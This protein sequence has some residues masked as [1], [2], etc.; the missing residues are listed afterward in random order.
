MMQK[1]IKLISLVMASVMVVIL[2]S[3]APCTA[4]SKK[5]L[6]KSVEVQKY[7]K[8]TKQWESFKLL[9]YAY[10]KKGD[11]VKYEWT[12]GTGYGYFTRTTEYTYR[13]NGKRKYAKYTQT[14]RE[15]D[16]MGNSYSTYTRTGKISY[17][18]NGTRYKEKYKHNYK[19]EGSSTTGSWSNTDRKKKKKY[20]FFMD[21]SDLT[22]KQKYKI[23]IRK[24]GILKKILQ[25]DSIDYKWRTRLRFNKEGLIKGGYK[26]THYKKNGL[27][28][29]VT[30][31]GYNG[32]YR[33]I[34][35]Y[36]KKSTSKIRYNS[37]INS[38]IDDEH[39]FWY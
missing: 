14:G 35:K 25:R 15:W 2:F 4:A 37:M 1:A 5:K 38:F 27:V 12:S 32:K 11:P 31:N 33:Y 8:D 24:K 13:K 10:N 39:F 34:F 20:G 30:Y 36:S 22:S 7:N 21:T 28:R 16:S 26:Y 6:V 18:K 19:H 29:S 23:K 3:A 17:R 9:E